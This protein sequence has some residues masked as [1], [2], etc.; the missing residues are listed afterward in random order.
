M[1]LNLQA[2]EQPPSNISPRALE[3]VRAPDIGRPFEPAEF[4]FF[5][6]YLRDSGFKQRLDWLDFL[7]PRDV[8]G[9]EVGLDCNVALLPQGGSHSVVILH[10]MST[11]RLIALANHMAPI[12]Y[13]KVTV[14]IT[15]E[16]TPAKRAALLH[17]GFDDVFDIQMQYPEVRARIRAHHR[18]YHTSRSVHFRQTLGLEIWPPKLP[19][20]YAAT[21]F[22]LTRSMSDRERMIL[23]ILLENFEAI[24]PYIRF[25]DTLFGSEVK[26]KLRSLRVTMCSVRSKVEHVFSLQATKSTGYRLTFRGEEERIGL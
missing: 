6:Y 14:A 9:I 2:A 1:Y 17:A 21:I 4:D 25:T 5:A 18:R 7:L 10:A 15:N 24:V 19:R 12:L 11:A 16:A 13:D 3:L 8:V 23:A 26:D 20:E 22:N